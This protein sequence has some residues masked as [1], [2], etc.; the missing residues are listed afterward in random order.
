MICC[1]TVLMTLMING[2]PF[3]SF[4]SKW[5]LRQGDPILPYMFILCMDVLSRLINMKA[6][7]GLIKG[8]R[9]SRHTPPINHLFFVD[10]VFLLGKCSVNEA[11]YFKECLDMFCGWFDQSFNSNN[12][13]LGLPLFRTGKSKDFNFLVDLLDTKL[14]SSL[15]LK[16]WDAICKP[17][18][19]GGLGF[20]KMMD[21]NKAL[22]SKWGWN[23]L[24][25]N[26]SLCLDLLHAKYIKTRNFMDAVPKPGH[27][28]FG[29]QFSRVRIFSLKV[30]AILLMME[31]PLTLGLTPGSQMLLI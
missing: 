30:P 25:G 6:E 10:D 3:Q 19:C 13:Y 23:L 18:A 16:A 2:A 4:K 24:K 21:F 22:L 14:A 8:F 15:C 20:R 12:T 9:M 27:F 1:S 5:G 31:P 29:K 28:P 7:E 26:K 11:F 17:K